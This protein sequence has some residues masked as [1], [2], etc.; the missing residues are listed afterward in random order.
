ML[1][2]SFAA[3][4]SVGEVARRRGHDGLAATVQNQLGF[5][6]HS[7][8]TVVFRSNRGDREK[9]LAWDG[10]GLVMIYGR[11]DQGT[12]AWPAIRD[13]VTRLSRIQREALF[14]SPGRRRVMAWRVLALAA[15]R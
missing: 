14:E 6:P 15:A 10:T 1:A 9:M 3:G 11:R 4:A 5:D 12:F 2:K 7:R 8:L 13:G